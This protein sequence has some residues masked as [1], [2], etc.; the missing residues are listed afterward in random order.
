[1]THSIASGTLLAV[2]HTIKNF[3]LKTT[4]N[5]SS[6]V[7]FL[8][9]KD[10]LIIL[11]IICIHPAQDI[12]KRWPVLNRVKPNL[13]LYNFCA[14][15]VHL[16][17]IIPTGCTKFIYSSDIF[18]PKFLATFMQ[19]VVLLMCAVYMSTYLATVCT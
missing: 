13:I 8:L 15:A 3:I 4:Q 10:R 9:Q 7:K 17:Y 2:S 11:D 1:M 14:T 12:Y 18:Q 6:I 19:L 5:P 16:Q